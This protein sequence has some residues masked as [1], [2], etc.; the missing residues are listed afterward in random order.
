MEFMTEGKNQTDHGIHDREKQVVVMKSEMEFMIEKTLQIFF[1]QK[2]GKYF[3]KFF[4]LGTFID[5]CRI[6]EKLLTILECHS[7]H[8]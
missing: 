2:N 6:S 7:Q 8:D 3:Q 1:F 5:T 4:Y